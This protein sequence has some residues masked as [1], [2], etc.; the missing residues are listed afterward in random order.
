M[1]RRI[2]CAR[3]H[4]IVAAPKEKVA[5]ELCVR[6]LIDI[7]RV[8]DQPKLTNNNE[9]PRRSLR[10]EEIVVCAVAALVLAAGSCY[11]CVCKKGGE[12]GGGPDPPAVPRGD[13]REDV[14]DIRMDA[15]P[16][17]PEGDHVDGHDS[18]MHW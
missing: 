5:C 15:G 4:I 10:A 17:S 1:H 2:S 9:R 6:D 3:S 18:A 14:Y 8:N 12:L 16:G 11:F 13:D 7:C